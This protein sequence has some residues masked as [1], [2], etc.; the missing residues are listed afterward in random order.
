MLEI[1]ACSDLCGLIAMDECGEIE[2]PVSQAVA[3][4]AARGA[5]FASPT[6]DR[7]V[8]ISTVVHMVSLCPATI[9]AKIKAGTFPKQ[10]KISAR[11]VGWLESEIRGFINTREAA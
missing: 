11:R 2:M 9:Y 1:Q 7:L 3:T 4:N 6:V 10:R 5:A 8:P